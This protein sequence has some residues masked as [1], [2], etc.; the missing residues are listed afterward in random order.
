MK[1]YIISV[2]KKDTEIRKITDKLKSYSFEELNKHYH[3]EFSIM[4]KLVDIDKLKEIFPK[5][6]LIKSIELRENKKNQRHYSL[7]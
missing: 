4:E 5:F 3:F 2:F 6:G 1:S 7:N